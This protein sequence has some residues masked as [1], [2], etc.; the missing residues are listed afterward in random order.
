MLWRE[1]EIGD[2]SRFSDIDVEAIRPDPEDP[3]SDLRLP[4]RQ[5]RMA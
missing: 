3:D 1:L 4:A 2:D 5:R